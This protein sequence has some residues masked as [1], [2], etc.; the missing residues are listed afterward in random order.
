MN[1]GNF[2]MLFFQ[3]LLS[4]P[5]FRDKDDC[6]LKQSNFIRPR[7][8]TGGQKTLPYNPIQENRARENLW[9]SL[10]FLKF[11][12]EYFI[13]PPKV[14]YFGILYPSETGAS[15]LKLIIQQ[16]IWDCETYMKYWLKISGF[17]SHSLCEIH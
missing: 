6:V 12:I 17:S 5:K 4:G 11:L 14:L 8:C 16:Q 13:Q 15:E 9:L 1:R 10:F 3:S 2:T 7:L